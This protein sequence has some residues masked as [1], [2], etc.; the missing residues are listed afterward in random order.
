MISPFTQQA[1]DCTD[2]TFLQHW[3]HEKHLQVLLPNNKR[4]VK[5]MQLLQ[6]SCGMKT[7]QITAVS[8][9]D[10]T[11]GLPI[12]LD[13]TD[14]S[15]NSC[16][17]FIII[18]RLLLGTTT[19]TLFS[20]VQRVKFHTVRWKSKANVSRSWTKIIEKRSKLTR[21]VYIWHGDK[22]TEA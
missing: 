18:L 12:A 2:T 4:V 17:S 16:H 22:P 1:S 5:T 6:P 11:L 10:N 19:L 21:N 20:H 8:H 3:C 7:N 14:Q 13:C 9:Y 15:V